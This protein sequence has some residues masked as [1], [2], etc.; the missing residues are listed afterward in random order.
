MS[1][2][3]Q[4][5]Y[6][7]VFSTKT[8]IKL[9]ELKIATSYSITFGNSKKQEMSFISNRRSGWSP[10]YYNTSSSFCCIIRFN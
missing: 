4:I 2:Y 8:E 3:T 9:S 5:L 1:T 10:A 7:I 6:Q